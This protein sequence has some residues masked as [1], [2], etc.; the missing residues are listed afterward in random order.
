MNFIQ[1]LLY[2]QNG[3][4]DVWFDVTSG[5]NGTLPNGSTSNAGAGW[6]FVTGWGAINFNGF[7]A[8]QF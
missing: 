1:D 8:S 4:S 3:R 7:V 5:S 2:S 6:D